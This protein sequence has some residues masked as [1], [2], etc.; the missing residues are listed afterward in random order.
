MSWKE[1]EV[2][3][4]RKEKK[5]RKELEKEDKGPGGRESE[6]IGEEIGRKR[7]I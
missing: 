4:A 5:L 2:E 7:G 3:E 6:R 1:I